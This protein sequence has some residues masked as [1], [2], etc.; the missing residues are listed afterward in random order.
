MK[1]LNIIEYSIGGLRS[2]QPIRPWCH[3]ME[4]PSDAYCHMLLV[5]NS[6]V[7]VEQNP[8]HTFMNYWNPFH[9][10]CE[11]TYNRRNMQTTDTVVWFVYAITQTTISLKTSWCS[12]CQ[13]STHVLVDWHHGKHIPSICMNRPSNFTILHRTGNREGPT[14]YTLCAQATG[15]TSEHHPTLV[16]LHLYLVYPKGMVV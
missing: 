15:S 7:Q 1:Q 5:I 9:I 2:S 6:I 4:L 10:Q 3:M 8:V 16:F 14:S 12:Y 13:P 11:F